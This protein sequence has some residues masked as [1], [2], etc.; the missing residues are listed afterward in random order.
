MVLCK[1]VIALSFC[2]QFKGLIKSNFKGKEKCSESHHLCS[3][4]LWL[5]GLLSWH[6]QFSVVR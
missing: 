3:N 5:I 2:F 6:A 1:A 4:M